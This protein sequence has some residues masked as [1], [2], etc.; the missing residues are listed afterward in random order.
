MPCR[1]STTFAFR[2]GWET[3]L[4][5]HLLLLCQAPWRSDEDTRTPV[6][7]RLFSAP[8]AGRCDGSGDRCRSRVGSGSPGLRSGRRRDVRGR[9]KIVR[10]DRRCERKRMPGHERAPK[11]CSRCGRRTAEGRWGIEIAEKELVPVS[12]AVTVLQAFARWRNGPSAR[13]TKRKECR[14][15]VVRQRRACARHT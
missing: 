15:P 13:A 2:A 1:K 8:I 14:A 10:A 5:I 6:P 9:S 3:H 12:I 4:D 7:L 11:R